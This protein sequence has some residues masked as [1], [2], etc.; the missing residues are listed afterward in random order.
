MFGATSVAWRVANQNTCETKIEKGKSNKRPVADRGPGT[1][2][3][4]RAASAPW[5]VL[6]SPCLVHPPGRVHLL[7]S[8]PTQEICT[9]TAMS[10]WART[11]FFLVP[12]A[13][14][15]LGTVAFKLQDD[16]SVRVCFHLAIHSVGPRG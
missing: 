8:P 12:V 3:I 11:A 6:Y 10:F 5:Y 7:P 13:A 16:E 14:V 9:Q 15:A 1:P 4:A 2:Y